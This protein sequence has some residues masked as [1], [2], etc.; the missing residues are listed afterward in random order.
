MDDFVIGDLT[1]APITFDTNTNTNTNT[2][3]KQKLLITGGNGLV[4]N[5]IRDISIQYEGKYE[6]FFF[7]VF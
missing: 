5:A 7:V 2:N 4:G 3:T 6:F 1:D